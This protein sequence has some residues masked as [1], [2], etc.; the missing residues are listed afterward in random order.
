[1][2]E[3]EPP[4]FAELLASCG[5]NSVFVDPSVRCAI[6]SAP[7]RV[8]FTPFDELED[9]PKIEQADTLHLTQFTLRS[10]RLNELAYLGPFRPA[11]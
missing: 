10:L 6:E 4:V 2:F 8:R 1:M 7:A 9:A 5:G 11:D 3:L